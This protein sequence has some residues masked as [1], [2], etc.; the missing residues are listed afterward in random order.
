MGFTQ[1]AAGIALDQNTPLGL[2]EQIERERST[3]DGH[4]HEIR[5]RINQDQLEFVS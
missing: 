1:H 5:I 4:V 3:S 2:S